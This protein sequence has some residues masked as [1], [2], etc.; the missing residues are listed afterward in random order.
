[1]I[2]DPPKN[3]LT[4]KYPPPQMWL[5]LLVIVAIIAF[6]AGGIVLNKE[7]IQ[8]DFSDEDLVAANRVL[9][10]FVHDRKAIQGEADDPLL[11]DAQE[12]LKTIKELQDNRDKE[13]SADARNDV[14][15][16]P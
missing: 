5:M 14:Q 4:S 15:D 11:K 3:L 9:A 12:L 2:F 13:A 10:E 6:L 7:R 1:M 16:R 8:F